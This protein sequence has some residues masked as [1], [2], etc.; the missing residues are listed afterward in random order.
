MYIYTHIYIDLIDINKK[1]L[2][3]R[4]QEVMYIQYAN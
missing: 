2:D 3:M 1:Q 4:Q